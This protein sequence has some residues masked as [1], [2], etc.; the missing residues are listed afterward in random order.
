MLI[1]NED[2]DNTIIH[3]KNDKST[4]EKIKVEKGVTEI[5]EEV[6]IQSD[7]SS[8]ESKDILSKNEIVKSD[9]NIDENSAIEKESKSSQNIH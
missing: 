2:K 3:S 5:Y 1:Y 8:E 6:S 7:A 4:D 9:K